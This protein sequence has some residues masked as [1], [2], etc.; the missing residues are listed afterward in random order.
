MAELRGCNLVVI[1]SEAKNLAVSAGDPSIAVPLG[2]TG[3]TA[4]EPWY[5]PEPRPAIGLRPNT[6]V[7]Y[8]YDAKNQY[9]TLL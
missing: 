7:P 2:M 4:I 3:P 1:L 5:I 9:D 6:A 8:R